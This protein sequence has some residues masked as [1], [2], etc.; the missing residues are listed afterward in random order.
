MK[1]TYLFLLLGI[2]VFGSA[3][4]QNSGYAIA[5]EKKE[6]KIVDANAALLM[7][8]FKSSDEINQG[9]FCDQQKYLYMHDIDKKGWEEAIQLQVRKFFDYPPSDVLQFFPIRNY[10]DFFRALNSIKDINWL[11]VSA[12][13]GEFTDSR[14]TIL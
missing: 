14:V 13:G 8:I 3:M 2:F 7:Q 4:A 12:H 10:S 6:Q 11:I 9:D 1:K 5:R